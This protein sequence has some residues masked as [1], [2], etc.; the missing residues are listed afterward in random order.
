[1]ASAAIHT[2]RDGRIYY[3]GRAASAYAVRG[4]DGITRYYSYAVLVAFVDPRAGRSCTT[5]QKYSATT[6]KH[7]KKAAQ[8]ISQLMWAFP[9][10]TLNGP[11]FAAQLAYAEGATAL[12]CVR[13]HDGWAGK[14]KIGTDNV[15]NLPIPSLPLPQLSDWL[16]DRGADNP[17]VAPFLHSL[18]ERAE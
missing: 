9:P 11:E 7:T 15:P 14:V 18:A 12:G 16:A 5:A 10:T 1:M 8:H 13:A 17:A 3:A 2:G 6:S 4:A